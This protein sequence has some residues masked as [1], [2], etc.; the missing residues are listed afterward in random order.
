MFGPGFD[1]VRTETFKAFESKAMALH[2]E[3]P[4]EI[5]DDEDCV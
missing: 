5:D 1:D 2:K 3:E 4:M